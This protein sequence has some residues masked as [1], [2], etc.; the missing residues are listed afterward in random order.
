MKSRL[1]SILS[2]VLLAGFLAACGTAPFSEIEQDSGFTTIYPSQ[3][4][5]GDVYVLKNHEKING[6]IVGIG[7]T[8]VIEDGAVVMGDISLIGGN[9]EI[10]GRVLGTVNVFAGTTTIDD[11]AIIT[12][13]INQIL[14]QTNT[15]PKASIN[16]EINTFIFPF[17]GGEIGKNILNIL[18]WMKPGFWVLLQVVRISLLILAT[19]LATALFTNPTFTVMSAIR[20]SP[21]VSWA[22]GIVIAFAVPIISLVLIIT[23]CLSPI[24]LIVLLA[25]LVATI[26]SWTVLSN[27]LGEQVTRWLDLDWNKEG[28]AVFGAVLT[29][30]FISLISLI[31]FGGFLINGAICAIGIGGIT[32]SRFG[33]ASS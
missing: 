25:Y 23:I 16:G 4:L 1:I 28:T 11:S 22:V 13:S 7:T 31:P 24:G 17:S 8:L 10:D 2:L 32:L 19:L 21:A 27:L 3:F 20:K 6:N 18:E 15:S 9:L 14:N 26:W 30:I 29:G 33:T 12:G 5:T